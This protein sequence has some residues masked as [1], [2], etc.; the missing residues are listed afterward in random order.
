MAERV[1]SVTR[2]GP[3]DDHVVVAM[4][5]AFDLPVKRR[6]GEADHGEQGFPLPCGRPVKG[7]S[8]GIGV[9]EQWA[10]AGAGEAGGDV[11]AQ[12]GLADPALLV[13]K[14]DDHELCIP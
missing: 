2:G 9:D 3:I 13:E 6:P 10:R 12:G 5:D 4:S 1:N 11:D 7:V 14:P 8:L